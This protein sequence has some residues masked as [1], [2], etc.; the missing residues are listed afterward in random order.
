MIDRFLLARH[1]ARKAA[2]YFSHI[3]R[4]LGYCVSE[5]VT[6]GGMPTLGVTDE[7]ALF[8][9]PKALE[10]IEKVVHSEEPF[11]CHESIEEMM[12]RGHDGKEIEEHGQHCVGIL[13]YRNNVCK[14]SRDPEISQVQTELKS[15]PDQSVIPGNQFRKHHESKPHLA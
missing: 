8:A 13:R 10:D 7:G 15:I 5:M 9:H 12:V 3:L 2:V 6:T 4:K 14:R 1:R 11:I